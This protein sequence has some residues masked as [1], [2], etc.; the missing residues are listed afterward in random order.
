M[1]RVTAA[2]A[3]RAVVTAKLRAIAGTAQ[4]LTLVQATGM[5]RATGGMEHRET[6][7][8]VLPAVPAT[9][10]ADRSVA[11]MAI[12]GKGSPQ[13]RPGT[14]TA[15]VRSVGTGRTPAVPVPATIGATVRL[16]VFET[17]TPATIVTTAGAM[18]PEAARIGEPDNSVSTAPAGRPGGAAAKPRPVGAKTVARRG[19]A[20]TAVRDVATTRTGAAVATTTA[21]RKGDSPRLAAT[22]VS[23][24]PVRRAVD[25]RRPAATSRSG[26]PARHP[27][28]APARAA[29]IDAPARTAGTPA[30]RAGK[31]QSAAPARRG[32]LS[33]AGDG[34]SRRCRKTSPD[35]SSAAL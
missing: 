4:P 18:A 11:T 25:A 16:V 6:A 29:V 33:L 13:A 24:S 35:A 3:R 32:R 15:I 23:G 5:N 20:G 26:D 17:A 14:A 27:T 22:S 9:A 31:G 8:A 34:T 1:H 2:T 21:G 28:D 10:R 19:G 12:P 7:V 30:G